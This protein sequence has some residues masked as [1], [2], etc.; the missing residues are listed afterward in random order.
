MHGSFFFFF[1]E[2]LLQNIIGKALT[3]ELEDV[4]PSES[5]MKPSF[6]LLV[7]FQHSFHWLSYLSSSFG[8]LDNLVN[9]EPYLTVLL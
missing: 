1:T 7:L 3:A 2:P 4:N 9:V 8:S 5:F 6:P